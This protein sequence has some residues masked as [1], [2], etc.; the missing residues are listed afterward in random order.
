MVAADEAWLAERR[1][2][3]RSIEAWMA[4]CVVSSEGFGVGLFT[5]RTL[6][7]AAPGI[8]EAPVPQPIKPGA[9]LTMRMRLCAKAY[10]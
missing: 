4:A 7:A 3:G 9:I 5:S 1:K 10:R 6:Y 2:T 8:E